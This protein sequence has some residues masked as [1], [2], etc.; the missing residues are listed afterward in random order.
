MPGGRGAGRRKRGPWVPS[1]AR[2]ERNQQ[3]CPPHRL[4]LEECLPAD[5]VPTPE[6]IQGYVKKLHGAG[7]SHLPASYPS[8]GVRGAVSGS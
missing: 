3:T 7:I 8:A 5:Q 4:H 1:G 2:V 6:L